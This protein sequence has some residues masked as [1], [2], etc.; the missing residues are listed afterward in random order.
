MRSTI[1]VHDLFEFS[2]NFINVA[3]TFGLDQNFDASFVNVVPATPTVVNADNSFQVIHDVLPWQEITNQCAYNGC[4]PHAAAHPDFEAHFALCIF[5]K[6]QTNVV[7]TNGSAVFVSA[8]D[9][10]FELARQKCKLRVQR[11]PLPQN[12]CIGPR[13]DHFI[14]GYAR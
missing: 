9:S 14:D 5:D 3:L 6:L 2:F 11:A 12:F 10:D 7:P 13:V 1:C 8:C 4:A